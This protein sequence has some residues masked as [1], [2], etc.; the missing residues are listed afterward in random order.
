MRSSSASRHG[1]CSRVSY[2]RRHNGAGR[3]GM[4]IARFSKYAHLAAVRPDNAKYGAQGAASAASA[5]SHP[6]KTDFVVARAVA[7]EK[8]QVQQVQQGVQR[9]DSAAPAAPTGMPGA[10]GEELKIGK[11][12]ER[13]QLFG[14][15]AALVAPQKAQSGDDSDLTLIESLTFDA[16]DWAYDPC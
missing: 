6:D 1:Q 3:C 10:T 7:V 16:D 9:S 2:Q 8:T 5:L 14:A 12:I 15:P 13:D 11:E 4:N